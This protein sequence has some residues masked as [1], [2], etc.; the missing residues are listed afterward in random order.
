MAIVSRFACRFGCF[1]ILGGL[2]ASAAWGD[3]FRTWTD[4]TGKHKLRAKLESV[5]GGKAILVREDGQKVRIALEKLSRADRDY[6]A[7][8]NADSPFEKMDGKADESARESA[9]SSSGSRRVRVDWSGSQAVLLANTNAEWHAS[10]P[11]AVAADF[12]PKSVAL[13]PK[14]D[15]FEGMTGVAVSRVANTA[16]VGYALDRLGTKTMRL[17]LCDLQTGR[18]TASAA[19]RGENMAPLALHDD[20]RQILM[21]SNEFGFGKHN[22]LEI[23]TIKGKDDVARSLI[24]TPYED[25][26]EPSRDVV[27][28][29]FIDAKRLATCSAGGKMAVWNL[30]TGQPVCH[31]QAS[32]D[33]FPA[34]SPDRKT[35]AI[36][37]KES[38]GLFDVDKQEMIASKETPHPLERPAVAF[39]PS[40]AKIGCIARDRIVVWD[41]ATGEVEK[42]FALPG[43][44]IAGAIDF[45]D[46]GF[47]LGNKQFL[48]ELKNQIKLW[49]Y[50][51]AEHTCSR[52][53]VTFFGVGGGEDHPGLLL[54]ARIPQPEATAMLKK[55][56]EQPDLFVFHKG[57]PVKL[58]VSGIPEAAERT[59]VEESL[60]NKLK[61]LGCPID[62]AGKIAP[63][64][65]SRGRNRV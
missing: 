50:L 39:S 44:G 36:A 10:V 13:P 62:P 32:Q 34:L 40:G 55:A 58:D 60:K 4:S 9:E 29:D 41:T 38:L 43:V 33:S 15:F 45:P 51:G 20:G 57:T 1:L 2:V 35:I 24:W 46:E 26:W 21:R 8:Q 56:L 49:H 53:G 18:V 52:S 54:A 48:I 23:W 25:G 5:E 3:D 27:W 6:I 12:Q 7:Q 30:A 59:K 37:S 31:I 28:A 19:I 63:W 64:R 42:D 22:R 17:L 11:A 61:D 65:R 16:V 47:L 14:A